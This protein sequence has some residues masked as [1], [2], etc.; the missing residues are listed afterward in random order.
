[1]FRKLRVH[2]TFANV[3][4]SLALFLALSTGTAYAANTTASGSAQRPMKRAYASALTSKLTPP[5]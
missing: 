5:P 2:L 3:V 4:A 1:M